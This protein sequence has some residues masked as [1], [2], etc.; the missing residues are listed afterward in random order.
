MLTLLPLLLIP[1][2]AP[3]IVVPE[4]PPVLWCQPQLDEIDRL[5]RRRTGDAKKDQW[6]ADRQEVL[7][8]RIVGDTLNF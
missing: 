2:L 6:I 5:Q 7:V 1:D 8:R 4:P 3:P